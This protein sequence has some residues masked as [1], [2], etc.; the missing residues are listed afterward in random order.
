VLA[1]RGDIETLIAR[2]CSTCMRAIIPFTS[3]LTGARPTMASSFASASSIGEAS[4]RS[5]AS[6]ITIGR[7]SSGECI[8]G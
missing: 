1:E 7:T 8:D 4:V 5:S 6:T 2:F 3:C